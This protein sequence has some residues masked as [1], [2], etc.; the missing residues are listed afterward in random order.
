[1]HTH[2]SL[3]LDEAMLQP[4]AGS[5]A[6]IS[7]RRAGKFVVLDVDGPLE[8]RSASEE[9]RRDVSAQ[10]NAGARNFAINLAESPYADSAGVGA[11]LA[12]RNS[13]HTAGGRLVLLSPQQRV[14]DMLKR[15]RVDRIFEFGASERDL[16]AAA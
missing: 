11:L 5:G 10:L 15:L 8:L 7:V 2:L 9:L 14:L 16:T 3:G 1:M 12:A 4:V 6:R 13:I